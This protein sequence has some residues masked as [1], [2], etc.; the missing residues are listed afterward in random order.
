MRGFVC[1]RFAAVLV[2]FLLTVSIVRSGEVA[3]IA[4]PDEDDVLVRML[5]DDQIPM[6][7]RTELINETLVHIYPPSLPA[8][9][10]SR[11][12]MRLVKRDDAPPQLRYMAAEAMVNN[13]IATPELGAYLV[14]ECRKQGLSGDWL[15][16]C[17]RQLDSAY[18]LAGAEL[19][20]EIVDI[21]VGASVR[22]VGETAG[23]ALLALWR[24]YEKDDAVLPA[25]RTLTRA[26][27]STKAEDAEVMSAAL[28][29]ASSLGDAEALPI[30]KRLA[31][32]PKYGIRLRLAAAGAIMVLGT[33]GDRNDLAALKSDKDLGTAAA[34]I[35]ASGRTR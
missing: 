1:R 33:D 21:L 5:L 18:S 23:T 7:E 3:G 27:L 19:K 24:I 31:H 22:E 28:Q 10:R 14:A 29:V 11:G 25:L 26:I 30:A 17:L 35:M 4:L 8:E 16:F 12:L 15:S 2:L 32:S 20:V 9:E 34:G 6:V 13:G